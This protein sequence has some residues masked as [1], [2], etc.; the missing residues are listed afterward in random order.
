VRDTPLGDGAD[1]REEEPVSLGLPEAPDTTLQGAS[2]AVGAEGGTWLLLPERG[3]HRVELASTEGE[4]LVRVRMGVAAPPQPLSSHEELRASTGP[5]PLP[6]PAP[7]PPLTLLPGREPEA[8]LSRG[9]GTLSAELAYRHEEVDEGEL[10]ERPL[11]TGLELR[12]GL[13]RELAP[14]RVWLRL[15]PE[16]RLPLGSTPV[17]GSRAALYLA[18]LPLKLRAHLHAALHTQT[19]E[20]VRRWSARGRLTVDR[21]VRLSPDLGLIPSLGLALEA[22]PSGAEPSVEQLDRNVFWRYGEEHA[23]RLT[24]RLSL[25]WQPFQDHVGGLSLA[26]TSNADLHTV[27]HLDGG[28]RWAAL[29]GGPLPFT[30]AE[31]SYG[32]SYRPE[33]AHRREGYLRHLVRGRLDWS[34]WTG[35]RGR[36]VLF[37]EDQLLLS[38]PFGPQNVLSMGARWDW[39]GGRGLRDTLPPEEEFKELLDSRRPRE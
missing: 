30:R 20:D 14:E 15:E 32:L 5:E 28:L 8:A 39:T 16:L 38:A 13:R 21:W 12:L 24:P 27:D 9:P 2:E 3:A 25:R 1:A 36:L 33:D 7:P 11:R 22:W 34:L 18:H 23:R 6:W 26:A 37:A 31:L 17:L 4:V 29:L 19:L 35:S 10:V